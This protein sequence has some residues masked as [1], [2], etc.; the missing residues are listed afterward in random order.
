MKPFLMLLLLFSLFSCAQKEDDESS[1]SA[2]SDDTTTDTTQYNACLAEASGSALC[3]S[4]S[5]SGF[6]AAQVKAFC[7]QQSGTAVDTSCATSYNGTSSNGACSVT[8]EGVTYLYRYYLGY[9]E[10]EESFC[11]GLSDGSTTTSWSA[12]GGLLT[13]QSF[14]CRFQNDQ[15]ENCSEL[16][17]VNE[18]NAVN[19]CDTVNGYLDT[20]CD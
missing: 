10:Y 7:D 3:I 5:S 4:F 18:E 9:A 6:S 12:D 11:N 2:S 15:K 1:S 19:F 16:K 20:T 8:T 14:Y 17:N 13:T